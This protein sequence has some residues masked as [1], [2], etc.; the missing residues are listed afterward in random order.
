MSSLAAPMPRFEKGMTMQRRTLLRWSVASAL[1]AVLPRH[2]RAAALNES[3]RRAE[4]YRQKALAQF[5]LKLIET[6]GA[7]ALAKWQE[8]KAAGQGVPVVLGGDDDKHT[9]SE[10]LTP[11]GPNGPLGPP[12]RSVEEILQKAEAIRFPGDLVA[13]RKTRM[14]AARDQL[15]ALLAANPN[16]RLPPMTETKD[17]QTRTLTRDETIAAMERQPPEPPIGEWPGTPD[18]LG[19]LSVANDISTGQPLAKVLI[20]VAPTDDW[21]T[22]PAYLRWG[23]WNGCPEAEYHVAAMRNWRDRY[24]AELVGISFDTINL[25]VA[26]K[27]KT[28]DEALA[29]AR[30][31]YVYC[32]DDIEQGVQTYSALAAA[33]MESDWWYFW[34]D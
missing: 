31:Q 10:L 19:G 1:G 7:E 18:T 22:V 9:F 11:F 5:P 23:G 32:P 30:E 26:R 3:E 6:S 4:E 28:R 17:G 25:R 15:K 21:T 34:W 13:H 29:L 24:G 16:M 14:D 20:G 12:L 33:L 27:P 2:A 8:L